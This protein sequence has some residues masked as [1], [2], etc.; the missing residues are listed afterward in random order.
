MQW[1]LCKN[2]QCSVIYH[3]YL[4]PC[5]EEWGLGTGYVLLVQCVCWGKY[6]ILMKGM[7]HGYIIIVIAHRRGLVL[8]TLVG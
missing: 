6:N 2:L 3:M 1:C 4:K 7:G 5:S 8:Y